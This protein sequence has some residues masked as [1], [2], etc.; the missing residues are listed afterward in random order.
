ML[1]LPLFALQDYVEGVARS[2][3]WAGLAIAPPY[4]LRQAFIAAATIGSIMLGAP[5]QAWVAVACTFA[6][7]GVALLVQVVLLLRRMR[8][9]LPSGPR[10]YRVR[11][12]AAASLPLAAV[13]LAVLGFNFADVILLGLF[14]PPETVAVYF[15]ATRILQFVVFASFAASSVTAPRIAEAKARGDVAALHGLVVRTARLTSAATM[16]IGVAVLLAA[17]LLLRMFGPGF[18]ASYWPLAVLVAGMMAYSLFGPAEDVLNMLGG[19]RV[20]AAVAGSALAVAVLLNL[21]LIPFYGILGAAIAMAVANVLRGA[22]LAHMA[23]LRFGLTTHV[24]ARAG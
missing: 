9:V 16:L 11:E 7:V 3:N 22:G 10:S 6:A 23:W 12:W 20:S 19:E 14:L 8:R 21:V 4:I 24:L 1:L 5:A 13:D 18:E 17:P 15:A 2:F